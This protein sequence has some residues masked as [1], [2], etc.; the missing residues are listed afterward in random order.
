MLRV[1]SSRN[2]SSH[3][4]CPVKAGTKYSDTHQCLQDHTLSIQN[5]I[6]TFPLIQSLLL[7]VVKTSP[8]TQIQHSTLLMPFQ[9]ALS[10]HV[11]KDTPLHSADGL[12]AGLAFVSVKTWTGFIPTSQH[13]P[14]ASYKAERKL[15]PLIVSDCYKL[16]PWNLLLGSWGR[17]TFFWQLLHFRKRWL[18]PSVS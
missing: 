5:L 11:P 2:Q 10:L 15:Y 4:P 7:P 6:N 13:L 1:Y 9:N 8:I 18:H 17:A 3:T 14:S 12:R 16:F